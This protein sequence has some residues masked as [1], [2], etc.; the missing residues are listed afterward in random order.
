MIWV[1]GFKSLQ[2]VLGNFDCTDAA[3]ELHTWVRSDIGLISPLVDWL[4]R[5]WKDSAISSEHTTPQFA[6]R[7]GCNECSMPRNPTTI[8]R[9]HLTYGRLCGRLAW[10]SRSEK[11]SSV[12]QGTGYFAM[13]V[14][15]LVRPVGCI[16]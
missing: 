12:P 15:S 13:V 4:K 16:T 8:V 5:L 2:S 9:C 7:H 14:M 10:P 3:L 11:L 1:G 6:S